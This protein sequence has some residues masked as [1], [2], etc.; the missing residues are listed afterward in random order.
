MNKI[1]FHQMKTG[2]RPRRYRRGCDLNE[3]CD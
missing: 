3:K 1:Y 2:K